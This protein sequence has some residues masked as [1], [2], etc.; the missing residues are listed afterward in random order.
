MSGGNILI[1]RMVLYFKLD[2][3]N[4]LWL[5]FCTGIKVREK[6]NSSDTQLLQNRFFIP[7]FYL[8]AFTPKVMRCHW[9]SLLR[10]R[11]PN[12]I[13]KKP[14]LYICVYAFANNLQ[15]IGSVKPSSQISALNQMEERRHSPVI[16][17]RQTQSQNINS[18]NLQKKVKITNN[19]YLEQ[20]K[21]ENNNVCSNCLSKRPRNLHA[22][23]SLAYSAAVWHTLPLSGIPCRSLAYP[24]AVWHGLPQPAISDHIKQGL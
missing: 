18:M 17:L 5:L 23:R 10:R 15:F 3:K 6:V 20:L 14:N 7:S 24:A 8:T 1:S 19:H 12:H 16:K 11:T 13:P 9:Q 2:E 4:R 21:Y 22:R